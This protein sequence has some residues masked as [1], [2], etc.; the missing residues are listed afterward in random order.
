MPGSVPVYSASGPS[1]GGESS[2]CTSVPVLYAL[3]K[4]DN[5]APDLYIPSQ[6]E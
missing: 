6:F 5:N 2:S 3:P 1:S 4:E